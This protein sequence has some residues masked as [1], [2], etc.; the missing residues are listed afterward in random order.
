MARSREETARELER[1]RQMHR[2][3]PDEKNEAARELAA[4]I[5]RLQ[6]ELGTGTAEVRVRTGPGVAVWLIIA[7][8]LGGIAFAAAYFAGNMAQG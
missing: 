4:T 5:E 6:A 7:V 8:L 3:M 2:S 1:L